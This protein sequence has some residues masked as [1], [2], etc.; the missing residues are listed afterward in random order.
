MS[1]T[2]RTDDRVFNVRDGYSNTLEYDVV[3]G[4]FARQLE[5]ELS[6]LKAERESWRPIASAP[7]DGT[8][9]DVWNGCRN[10]DVHC[11][12]HGVWVMQMDEGDWVRVP[13]VTHW[14]PLPPLPQLEVLPP[15]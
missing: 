13:D 12:S 11:N 2:P 14:R 7:R 8:A 4:D 10:T 3:A 1:D 5:R 15:E 6:A 9:I